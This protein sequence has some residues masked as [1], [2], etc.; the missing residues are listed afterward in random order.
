V[1]KVFEFKVQ[2][3]TTTKF[4]FSDW[5]NKAGKIDVFWQPEDYF[6]SGWCRHQ[7]RLGGFSAS[8]EILS[9]YGDL[10]GVMIP[11]K[12]NDKFQSFRDFFELKD[13]IIDL[14]MYLPGMLLPWH[15]DT[16]PTYMSRR[17]LQDP[18][19]IVRIIVFLHDSAPGHQLWI[20]DN[21]CSGAAGSWF[22]WQAHQL[23]MA[24]NL[25]QQNRYVAQITGRIP[26]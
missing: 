13:M 2:E 1:E 3:P 20:G 9:T 7:G 6:N 10:V 26:T 5:N 4:C 14:S 8:D 15:H 21:F 11:D 18:G 24:A 17:N 23:H 22:S 12:V 19:D 25:G 16:F